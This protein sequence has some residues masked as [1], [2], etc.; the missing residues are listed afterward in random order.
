M[1]RQFG[2]TLIVML[3]AGAG[4]EP[5]PLQ[6]PPGTANYPNPNQTVAAAPQPQITGC[7]R[8][9]H[10]MNALMEGMAMGGS[11]GGPIG[12]GA[13]LMFGALKHLV[14]FE[15]ECAQLHAKIGSEQQKNQQLEAAIEQELARQRGFENQVANA[16]TPA[17][18]TAPTGVP[19][20]PPAREL[21]PNDRRQENITLAALN[22]P[23]APPNPASP[24]KN[25]EVRDVN[26]DG[27]P[28][29]WIYYNPQKP[30]EIMRQEESTKGDGRVDSWSYFKDGRL[31]R[32]DVDSKALGRPDTVFYYDGDDKIARE[33]RDE[34][35]EGIMTY[36]AKYHNGR[37][38]K[39]ERDTRGSGR[40]DLWVYYDTSRDGEVVTKEE[41]DLNG[42]GSADLWSYFENGHLVRR[43]VSA[44]GLEI[45][46]KQDQ[47]PAPTAGQTPVSIPGS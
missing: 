31:I 14:T 47:L 45:L 9:P 7:Q 42:D 34:N 16:T 23:T 38:E 15:S 24:F 2:A 17:P 22:K 36:R 32:R 29:L 25:V 39:L 12:A 8:G 41:R 27:V 21:S 20:Q 6:Y 37:I 33:E 11:I 5:V 44:I 30:G 35:G 1:Y 13:G 28:D 3:M 18:G 19:P 40:T 26:G 10:V 46:A 4:C 43:D